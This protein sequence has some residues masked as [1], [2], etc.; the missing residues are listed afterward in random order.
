MDWRLSGD[1]TMV[2]YDEDVLLSLKE[3][4]EFA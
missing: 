3:M 1:E 4:D 2:E